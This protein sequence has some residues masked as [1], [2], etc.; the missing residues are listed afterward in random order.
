MKSKRFYTITIALV[1]LACLGV[2]GSQPASGQTYTV[3]DL[4]TLPG[5][6]LSQAR[7]INDAAE[8]VGLCDSAVLGETRS[9]IWKS[10]SML[11]LGTL[12]GA[13]FGIPITEAWGMND[14]G[15]IVGF[16]YTPAGDLRA[17]RSVGGVMTDLGTLGGDDSLARGV[18]NL[19]V[20]VGL[21]K[22]AANAIN[23][24]A[25]R[26]ESG[27]MTN[28]GTLAGGAGA[29]AY[30]INT[31][32][33][34][35][36]GSGVAGGNFHAFLYSAGTMTDLGTLGG[37]QSWGNAINDN[38]MVVGASNLASGSG[39]AFLWTSV[40]GMVDLGTFGGPFS[41]AQDVNNVGQIVGSADIASGSSRAFVYDAVNGMQ[42][43]NDLIGDGTGWVLTSTIGINDDGQIAGT[44]Q[45]NGETR[46]F[47]LTPSNDPCCSFLTILMIACTMAGFHL[48]GSTRND[49]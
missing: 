13:L 29:V 14:A 16:S 49:N 28:L 19:G 22:T 39:H 45:H 48:I 36:G 35:V 18:N 47:L 31:A 21:A 33:Q 5:A 44:G 43:L 8:I 10:G 38:G 9:F 27:V 24:A 6:S 32:G 46:A 23:Y 3:T 42:N 20:V 2:L 26:W 17:F 7:A 40:G 11:E 12:G 15:D 41:S 1:F 30:D 4:G 37:T 25:F 34:I